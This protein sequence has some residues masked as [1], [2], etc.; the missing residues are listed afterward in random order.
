MLPLS[1]E[2]GKVQNAVFMSVADHHARRLDPGI[3]HQLKRW[4]T[5]TI[6]NGWEQITK[7]NPALDGI[8]HE[9]TRDLCRRWGRWSVMR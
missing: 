5:P 9:E 6:F 1:D 4:N 8:N 2:V 7:R 3:L